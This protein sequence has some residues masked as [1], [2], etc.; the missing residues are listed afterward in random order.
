MCKA[1]RSS[2]EEE[3]EKAREETRDGKEVS[4]HDS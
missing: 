4:Q 3:M 2:L 1:P